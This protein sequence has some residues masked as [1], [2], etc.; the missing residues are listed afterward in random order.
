MLVL[1]HLLPK[2]FLNI[3][4]P[5]KSSCL[6]DDDGREDP[7]PPM[8]SHPPATGYLAVVLSGL[9]NTMSTFLLAACIPEDGQRTGGAWSEGDSR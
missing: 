6:L 5:A 2:I 1:S 9:S 3:S 4:L 8:P 7:A